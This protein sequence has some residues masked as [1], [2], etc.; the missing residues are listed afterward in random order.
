MAAEEMMRAEDGDVIYGA[1]QKLPLFGKPALARRV[2]HAELE[3]EIA[4]GALQFQALRSELAKALFRTALA[5]RI[6][7]VGAVRASYGASGR[8]IAVREAGTGRQVD[9]SYD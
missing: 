2:A 7:G 3:V 4:G 9:L 8:L 1:E 5:E 6:A